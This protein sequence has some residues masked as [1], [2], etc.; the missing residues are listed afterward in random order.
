M[1]RSSCVK[2]MAFYSPARP[3]EY[4]PDIPCKGISLVVPLWL[5][6]KS[7]PGSTGHTSILIGHILIIWLTNWR[8]LI[9]KS[10]L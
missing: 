7:K 6:G 1:Q 8:D 4:D 2:C 10:I 9:L 5:I 3:N